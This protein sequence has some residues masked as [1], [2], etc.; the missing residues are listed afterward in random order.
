M[1]HCMATVNK[2][3]QI[4]IRLTEAEGEELEAIAERLD[5][6]ISQIAREGIRERMAALK[7]QLAE[8]QEVSA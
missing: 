1:N 3:K 6:P 5:V 8:R 7:R 4:S 2:E